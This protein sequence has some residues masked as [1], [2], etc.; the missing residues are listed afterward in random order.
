MKENV[1][2]TGVSLFAVFDGHGDGFVAEFCKEKLFE[3]ISEKIIEVKKLSMNSME[4]NLENTIDGENL[5]HARFVN[6]SDVNYGKI[7]TN[8][9]LNADQKLVEELRNDLHL[10]GSTAT[11]A[12]IDGTKLTVANVGDSRGV[13]CDSNGTAIPLSFDHKPDKESEKTRIKKAGGYI[14]FWG[15]WRVN[16]SLAVSR[17][18]GDYFLK[19]DLVIADPDV[20]E[21][22][23]EEHR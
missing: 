6:G 3:N 13:M 20:L 4:I 21:F 7:L 5:D 11:I 15:V 2:G 23:L 16:G 8:E 19:P 1:N 10:S 18:I 12:V 14:E 9:I 17:A 22:D